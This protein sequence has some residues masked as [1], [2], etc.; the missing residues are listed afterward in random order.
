MKTTK[1]MLASFAVSALTIAGGYG[2][3]SVVNYW[4]FEGGYTDKAGTAHGT[5]GANVSTTAGHTGSPTAAVFPASQA[6]GFTSASYVDLPAGNVHNSGSDAFSMSFW[7]N[8]SN[9]TTNRG[10]LDFSGNGGEGPQSLYLSATNTL[11]FRVD[12]A[13]GGGA[14]LYDST[15]SPL[16]DGNW[17]FVAATY[18]PVTGIEVHIDGYGVDAS[19]GG[20]GAVNWNTDQY[21][22]AFNVFGTTADRGLGGSLD[23]V[24]I[25]SGILSEAQITGLASGALTPL[26][27]PEPSGTVLLGLAGMT[28]MLRR[29]R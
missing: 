24:A 11:A 9:A 14:A 26:E 13:G 12:G 17:H 8:I 15:A 20:F 3:A 4:D 27:V 7:F 18:D 22:G 2:A 19:A 28:F 29:R 6:G 1:P 25:Y 10:I 5:A 23:D 16:D 21:L